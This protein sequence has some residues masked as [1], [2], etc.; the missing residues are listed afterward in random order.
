MTDLTSVYEWVKLCKEQKVRAD[1]T[2]W[3]SADLL[4]SSATSKK[5]DVKL[6]AETD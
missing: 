1:L 4:E 2:W 6:Y 3:K 5:S